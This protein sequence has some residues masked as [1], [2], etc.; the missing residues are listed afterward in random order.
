MRSV[1]EM[2]VSGGPKPSDLL[3]PAS[4]R[5]AITVMQAIGGSTNG[6]VHLAAI[7]QRTD[8]LQ[9]QTQLESTRANLTAMVGQ[10]AVLEHAIALLLGKAPAETQVRNPRAAATFNIGGPICA[11]VCTV[12]A[13]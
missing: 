6:V 11:S 10:R 1:R 7:A 3:T 13:R 8:V 5:N 9:A 12:L 2:A 4:F